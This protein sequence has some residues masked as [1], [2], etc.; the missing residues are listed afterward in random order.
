[1]PNL[2]SVGITAG[3]PTSGTGT[4][5]TIDNLIGAA[6][7]AAAQVL[8]VQGV[9]SGTAQAVTGPLTDTQLRAT[10]VPVSGTVT[11]TTSG[12]VVAQGSTTAGE[13]GPLS[14]G[15]VTTSAPTYSAGTTAPLSLGTDGTLRVTT[16]ANG[17]I[18]INAPPN[19]VLSGP[20]AFTAPGTLAVSAA[21]S[22]SVGVQ[23]TG[24]GTGL[25]FSFEATE[26]S[27]HWFAVNAFKQDGTIV[28][29]GTANGN[30]IIPASGY[31]QVRVNLTAIASGTETFTLNASAASIQQP[32][33]TQGV[34]CAIADGADVA[35]G[36]ITDTAV[37]DPTASGSE[38]ALLKGIIS[39]LDTDA[40]TLG[41]AT[42][43]NSVPVTMASDQEVATVT[44]QYAPVA[45]LVSGAITSAMTGTTSTS[46]VAAPTGSLHNHITSIVV[47]NSHATVGT[48]IIIQDGSGGTTLMTIPA[49]PAYGGAVVTL[50]P[51]LRQPTAATALFCANVTTGSS[52]KVSAVGYT[53]L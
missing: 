40:V 48:D 42:K 29:S 7:T 27:S 22:G 15:A 43:A 2:T 10:P 20:T 16:S 23:A 32:L 34:S 30:W 31:V 52:T 14:Q 13:S 4:V 45:N 6:G 28:T 51:P 41:Q 21:G 38:I 1:M 35:Q 37:T 53:A 24:T 9:A 17:K 18:T 11:A 5:S 12:L 36:S 50:N 49:A 26:D 33:G 25:V 47:S 46:L 39:T 8:S 44:A 19:D 3:I